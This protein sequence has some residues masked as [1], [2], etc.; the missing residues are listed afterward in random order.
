MNNLKEPAFVGSFLAKFSLW[1]FRGPL[2]P[3][4]KLP[5]GDMRGRRL[6]PCCVQERP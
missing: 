5:E 2:S 6:L 1:G 4:Q 3:D